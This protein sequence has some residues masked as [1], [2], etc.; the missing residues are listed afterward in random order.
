MWR[1]KIMADV[2]LQN[3]LGTD[4]LAHLRALVSERHP[5]S[6]PAALRR[7]EKYLVQ[8]FRRSGL[9]VGFHP[10]R[11]LGGT[12]RNVIA[13]H[14]PAGRFV[15]AGRDQAPPGA[16]II[17][18]HY[19]TVRG[20]PGADDNASGLA[21]MLEVARRV[22]AIPLRRELRFI[23]FC[24]EEE[25]LLG[26]LAYASSLRAANQRIQGAII[27][28]CV[29]Y[30]RSEENSQRAPRGVPMMV[31]STG[32]FLGIVGNAASQELTAA[33]ESCM[34]R[35]TGDL[36]T[37]SLVVPG[38]GEQLPDTRRSDHA[39]FWHYGYPAVMLTDTADFRNPNYHAS[40]DTIETLDLTFM[41]SVVQ[42]VTAA[43]IELAA[44][45][46]HPRP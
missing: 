15:A 16:L 13:T 10:F 4:L 9:D 46:D 5:V 30:S 40:S 23:A 17:G 36:R 43:A 26:S 33:V 28:E 11:A 18:A 35:H 34:R 12:Y 3:R 1:R 41:Q 31:P 24:L 14:P 20:S 25:D 6:A 45:P 27:L 8:Q 19:D 42:A 44:L 21:V 2:S 22:H 7:A 29:G 37:I 32:D 39:A 38:N